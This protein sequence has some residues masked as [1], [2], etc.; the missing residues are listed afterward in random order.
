MSIMQPQSALVPEDC[1]TRWVNDE[2][3][4]LLTDSISQLDQEQRMNDFKRME[5]ILIDEMP[6][7]PLYYRSNL[8]LCKPNIKNV[9]K[10]LLGHTYLEYA[11]VE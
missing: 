7:L 6:I 10:N 2:Y 3:N 8:Y 5:E 1:W 4:T 9:I 11:Y